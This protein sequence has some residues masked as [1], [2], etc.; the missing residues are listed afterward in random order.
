MLNKKVITRNG[1]KY[2]LLGIGKDNK[3]YYL[4]EESWDCNWYWGFGYVQS[5][6][7]DK[8]PQKA[9]DIRTHTHFDSLFLKDKLFDSFVEFF[10]ETPFSKDEIWQLLE[11]MKTLYTLRKSSELFFL[12][13]TNIT[14]N[15]LSENLKNKEI[16]NHINM[17]L[18]PKIF[19]EIQKIMEK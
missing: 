3:H 12:G 7:N 14:K 16:Y 13:G 2:Y 5:F 1:K 18:M 9:K 17:D 11:L 19:K 10:I 4:K 15:V 6:T 8:N